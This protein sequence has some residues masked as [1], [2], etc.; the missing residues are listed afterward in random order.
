M[1]RD[2]GYERDDDPH[3]EGTDDY[4]ALDLSKLDFKGVEKAGGQLNV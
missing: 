1:L 3:G 4:A 2:G